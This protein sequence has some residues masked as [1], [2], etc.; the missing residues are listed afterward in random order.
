MQ[1]IDQNMIIY[2]KK[3]E[4]PVSLMLCSGT[5]RARHTPYPLYVHA[6]FPLL[7]LLSPM[8]REDIGL[9]PVFRASCTGFIA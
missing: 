6:V 3:M 5:R 4:Y 2:A 7:N 1:Q 9:A 8:K